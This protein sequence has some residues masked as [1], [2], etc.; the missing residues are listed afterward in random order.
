MRIVRTVVEARDATADARRLGREVA[1]VPT[2][3][4]FHEGHLSLMRRARAQSDLLVV[5]LF[6]NPTQFNDPTDLD[7]YPRDE[8]RDAALA[9]EIGVDLLFAPT[10]D[11]MYP[12][13]FVTRV[14]V[15]A[16]GETLEG[17]QRGPDHF[18]GVS[19]VVA[20]LLNIVGPER[21]Y[22]GQKDAQQ[23][24]VVKQLVRDLNIPVSIETCPTVRAP[25]G[26]ALSSR[27]A[28]LSA[29]ER[30]R[31]TALYRALRAAERVIASGERDPAVAITAARGEL[32]SSG[33]EPDY[34]ELVDPE[35]FAPVRALSGD[36][37]A[38]VAA[39]LESARLI[40]NLQIHVPRAQAQGDQPPRTEATG[41]HNSTVAA[42]EGAPEV[43]ERH[44]A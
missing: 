37:L 10:P 22:F 18:D 20:K 31:A 38:V 35:R 32:G 41:D 17:A 5:S 28:R 3:G 42:H 12:E 21:A 33:V 43:I 44:A 7:I 30:V 8:R 1:L 29:A 36:V 40:D 15:G 39:S 13:G 4:A 26:L 27:N 24:V 2:M 9:A 34:F 14:S 11:E 19:T 25:D 16:V 23:T 6:V